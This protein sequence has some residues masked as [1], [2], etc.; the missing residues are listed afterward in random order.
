MAPV[1]AASAA[2][3]K[4]LEWANDPEA[5]LRCPTS[6]PQGY[7]GLYMYTVNIYIYIYAHAQDIYIIGIYRDRYIETN[8][9]MRVFRFKIQMHM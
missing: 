7:I 8:R 5:Q 9:D 4:I 6:I 3:D 2:K 1:K